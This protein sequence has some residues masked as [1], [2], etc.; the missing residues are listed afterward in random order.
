MSVSRSAAGFV[1]SRRDVLVGVSVAGGLSLGISWPR[2]S[3]AA[4]LATEPA[5]SERAGS[6]E[7]NAWIVIDPDDSI[8]IRLAHAEMGQGAATALPMIVAEELACDWAKIKIEYASA[9]RNHRDGGV[10]GNMVTAG[11]GGTRGSVATLQKAGANA[12][13]RLVAA[14]A[15]RWKVPVAQCTAGAGRVVH[16]ASG[17][18]FAYGALAADAAKVKL[19]AE[20][21]V[22]TPDQF[23][24][25]G[26]PYPRTDTPLKV[27]GSAKFAM[28]TIRP[29]MLIAVVA[30]CPVPGGTL[31]HVETA[32]AL[33]LPG[34]RAV[35]PLKTAVAV[36]ADT[37]WQAKQALDGLKVEWNFGAGAGT[38]TAQF[39]K[40]YRDALDGPTVMASE[41]GTLADGF[42][43]AAKTVSA[44]YEVPYLA[45]APM[46]PLNATV[47]LQPGRLDMWVGSQSP[48]AALALAAEASGLDPEQIF[49]HN[50]FIGGGFG[51][52]TRHDELEHAI[53]V[54]KVV[55]RPVKLIW[56]REQDLQND[57]FRP[58]AALS[59]KAGLDKDGTPV[60]LEI[61]TAVSSLLRS[62]GMNK[63]EN[64][65]EGPAVEGLVSSPYRVAHQRVGCVLKNTHIPV[66][67]WRSVG[68]SQNAFALESFVDEMAF[69]AGKDAWA[70]RRGLIDRT[71]YL[72]V[73]DVLLVK[74]DW[75]K[76][77][78][79]GRGRGMAIHEC[80][81][82]IVG[83]IAEVTVSPAGDVK[84]DRVVAVVD[85]GHVVNPKIVESQIQG[86]VIWGLSA[87]LLDEITI[88]DGRVV[89]SNFAD[90]P[91][92]RMSDTPEIEVHFALSGG[93]KWGGIGE[94]GAAPLAPAVCNAIFAATGKRIRSLP[95]RNVSLARS[96]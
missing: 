33:R 66:S 89:Q 17:R 7:I 69:A 55:K 74:G 40:L 22:K 20:P 29:G 48:M 1:L 3:D 77:M 37:F 54:A 45:H 46:E 52:K 63:V 2:R 95:I 21:A 75:G 59:F 70:F 87:A 4:M 49:I 30:S 12:R 62:L 91:I 27:D 24:V 19:A 13:E 88:K 92:A 50:C 39:K 85:C 11:S 41:Q 68:S 80:Y 34:V 8:T 83:Q 42:A 93:K 15:K 76:P 25:I 65:V 84:V 58:Q 36:A 57:R 6:P 18:A 56:T 16:T 86:A 32:D 31:L 38:D 64:G 60:A 10:Y 72:G 53:A 81:G 23:T 73:M 9:T 43:A 35:V 5:A 61:K 78:A 67:F 71:D 44:V 26:R 94:P 14:A 79:P 28:D 82:S 51:R 47:D 90:Y 96:V